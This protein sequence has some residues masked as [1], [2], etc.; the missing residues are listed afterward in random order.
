MKSRL[1]VWLTLTVAGVVTAQPSNPSTL[2]QDKPIYLGYPQITTVLDI[3][4]TLAPGQSKRYL[5]PVDEQATGLQIKVTSRTPEETTAT[6]LPPTTASTQTKSPVPM[7]EARV[8]LNPSA[9]RWRLIIEANQTLGQATKIG[10]TAA[11]QGGGVHA[12]F[13][14][15]Q[16]RYQVGDQP[17]I[18]VLAN[19]PVTKRELTL[20]IYR[21]TQDGNKKRF[22]TFQLKRYD[23]GK[24]GD[25]RAGDGRYRGQP[26][27][28]ATKT[29]FYVVEAQIPIG[30]R[31]DQPIW[32]RMRAIMRVGDSAPTDLDFFEEL[33]SGFSSSDVRKR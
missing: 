14:D 17:K 21:I 10:L 25:D 28:R 29:G 15:Y 13:G 26:F 33:D 23:T 4:D 12:N 18:D 20:Q 3:N 19:G 9:G 24:K 6:L 22:E 1:M 27:K 30:V 31:N 7:G 5:I 32:R 2:L 8:V 11:L 16:P